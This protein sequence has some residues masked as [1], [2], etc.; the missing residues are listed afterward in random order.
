MKRILIVIGIVAAIIVAGMLSLRIY[1]KSFSPE[2][3]TEYSGNGITLSVA[4]C[5]PSA[6]GRVIFGDLIPYG[7]VWRTGANEATIFR[8]NVPLQIGDDVLPAG[9][10][11]LFTVPGEER[12]KVIFNEETGQWGVDAFNGGRANRSESKDVLTIEVP[13]I[14]AKDYF[15]SFTISL[16]AMGGEMEMVMMWANTMVVVPMM[17][18][19]P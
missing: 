13:A 10:Y 11:S 6:S 18:S 16:D 8:T 15:E 5:Q 19:T 17:K 7:E 2:A 3:L 12:W 9:D 14:T 4:Y 1:T